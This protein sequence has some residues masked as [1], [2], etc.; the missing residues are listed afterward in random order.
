MQEYVT[1]FKI[2]SA[3]TEEEAKSLCPE[4]FHLIDSDLNKGT[5]GHYIYLCYKLGTDSQNAYTNF[6][7]ESSII[8]KQKGKCSAEH[9]GIMA[10]YYRDGTN[11]N[12]KAGG[13]FVYLCG[14]K[15]PRFSPV[16]EL[17]VQMGLLRKSPKEFLP[18]CW[19]GE[20]AAADCN[21]LAGG[22]HAY[23]YMK[24]LPYKIDL[25]VTVEQESWDY[26]QTPVLAHAYFHFDAHFSRIS[27]LVLLYEGKIIAKIKPVS[28]VW[29]R[30]SL[31][32]SGN[33]QAYMCGLREERKAVSPVISFEI[34]APT[35][36]FTAKNRLLKAIETYASVIDLSDLFLHT[37][38][39][40]EL[41]EILKIYGEAF[42]VEKWNYLY[43]NK[44]GEKYV[45]K[46]FPRYSLSYFEFRTLQ[47]Y[48]QNTVN[49]LFSGDT[50]TDLEKAVILYDWL[51]YGSNF[52]YDD[53]L[54]HSTNAYDALWKRRAKSDGFSLAMDLLCHYAGLNCIKG[55]STETERSWNA[56]EI[57]NEWFHVDF[58]SNMKKRFH[59]SR[60]YFLR[61]D[62][63]FIYSHTSKKEKATW[64]T[65]SYQFP[66]C[67]SEIYSRHY[68]FCNKHYAIYRMN[69]INYF[70]DGRNIWIS[71]I[72][73]PDRRSVSYGKDV[74]LYS[75]LPPKNIWFVVETT[76][77]C[78]QHS[79]KITAGS[80]YNNYVEES[81]AG[82]KATYTLKI[83]RQGKEFQS[84]TFHMY[85]VLQVDFSE[86]GEYTLY[87]VCEN[88]Y[89]QT[90]SERQKVNVTSMQDIEISLKDG[91]SVSSDTCGYWYNNVYHPYYGG[92]I[93]K[94]KENRGIHVFIHLNGI[95]RLTLENINIDVADTSEQS[96]L[97]LCENGQDVQIIL[98]GKNTLKSGKNCPGI[99]LPYHCTVINGEGELDVTGGEGCPGIGR[100][101]DIRLIIAGGGITS[102]GGNCAAGI[103]TSWGLSGGRIEITDGTVHAI[104]GTFGA[105]IGGGNNGTVDN[106]VITGGSIFTEVQNGNH[107][108]GG[109][110]RP[111]VVP[112]NR[113]GQLL[114]L[115]V[116]QDVA[117]A[118]KQIKNLSVRI[119][120]QEYAYGRQNLVGDREGK[121]YLYLP[122]EKTPQISIE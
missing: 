42:H 79:I 34:S 10:A 119:E 86:E 37:D 118:G 66:P 19:K 33:Y 92:L 2:V 41:D 9:N 109:S 75:A 26:P 103:G 59:I 48:V 5:G 7:L 80:L 78:L 106:I 70:S 3:E 60:D 72:Y 50:A 68:D 77:C 112:V 100:N 51:S 102:R 83:Y 107:F 27:E 117:F 104:G 111:A 114:S 74:L 29:Y 47:S 61:T 30:M 122:N 52:R 110:T 36:V 94:Q 57:E 22:K 97:N 35:E 69:G 28:S 62:K 46:I 40:K 121:F 88:Q 4:N 17:I 115:Y 49:H 101:G 63:E 8:R 98:K 6:F 87:V 38:A 90:E 96:A 58:T 12:E 11:I 23:I 20:D 89:G 25:S 76:V 16:T 15:D 105:A 54:A 39:E 24:P 73:K 56:V 18:I 14:T 93:L 95:R 21:K 82:Y 45:E 108:G 43:G 64:R 120:N 85:E 99:F 71:S 116:Y 13:F 32:K 53:D 67:R 1:D 84:K 44:N 113:Q 81:D 91:D 31:L 55:D 65:G